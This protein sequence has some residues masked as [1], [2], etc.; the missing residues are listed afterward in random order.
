MTR[1]TPRT[2]SQA[3]MAGARTASG[4]FAVDTSTLLGLA[5]AFGV[6]AMAI[7][8]GG[9]AS[10]YLDL[11]AFVIVIG[12]TLTVTAVSFSAHDLCQAWRAVPSALLRINRNAREVARQM[13][14][15]AEAARRTG[16]ETLRN[17]LPELRGEPFL[18]R[19][20]TLIVEGHSPDEIE[21]VLTAEA[22]AALITLTRTAAILR[23]AAEVAPSM[24][25][26]GTLIGLVQMLGAL[27]NPSAIGPAMAV[28]LLATLYGAVL[29][30]MILTPLAGKL[31]ANADQ[32]CL[33]GTL[34]LTGSLSIA[35]QENPRRLEMLLN[36]VLPMGSRIQYF[37][38]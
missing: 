5:G 37:D 28:A 14:L 20:L 4:R 32:D 7:I 24:G 16:T 38:Q 33:I 11:S 36:S 3:P 29:G 26:I 25:L 2:D 13:L 23:R 31:E 10:S 6:V 21:R 34:Y 17:V 27:N 12:G 18:A 22:E 19:C 1:I 35:R 8:S 9:A 30:N 15:L